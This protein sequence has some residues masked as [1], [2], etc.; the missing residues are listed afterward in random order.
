MTSAINPNVIQDN[1]PVAKSDVRTQLGIARDEISALQAAISANSLTVVTNIAALRLM[2]TTPTAVWVS[3]GSTINDN[4][5]GF[6]VYDASDTTTADNGATVIVDGLGHRWKRTIYKGEYYPEWWGSGVTAVPSAMAAANANGGGIVVLSGNTYTTNKVVFYPKCKLKGQNRAA[7]VLRLANGVNDNLIE[8]LNSPALFGTNTDAGIYDWAIEDVTLD[9][10]MA[11]QSAGSGISIY[12]QRGFMKNVTIKNC[13]EHGMRTEWYSFASTAQP[14]TMEPAFVNIKIETTGQYGWWN[15]GAHDLTAFGVII[16]NASQTTDNTYDGFLNDGAG[17]G[18]FV[19]LHC[20]NDGIVANRHRFAMYSNS[21]G[22]FI[23]SHFE[24]GK[25]GAVALGGTFGRHSFDEACQFYNNRNGGSLMVIDS[26]FN[27]IRGRF[28]QDLTLGW[29][30][31]SAIQLG[32]TAPANVSGNDISIN[33]LNTQTSLIDVTNSDGG[34]SIRIRGFVNTPAANIV[35]AL[36]AN[37]D[38]DVYVVQGAA[39]FL[40]AFN[41]QSTGPAPGLRAEFVAGTGI[42]Q[43]TATQLSNI[44]GIHVCTTATAGVNDAIKMPDAS[45]DGIHYIY[46][47]SGVA[48]KLFPATGD[49]IANQGVNVNLAIPIAKGAI[50]FSDGANHW[51]CVLGA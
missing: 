34:N 6:F 31:V 21:S 7:S 38:F 45:L 10:N 36:H 42:V 33:V 44:Y 14:V 37:D 29:P 8:G 2:T 9:G 25:T 18:R 1:V 39:P 12:G 5:H 32:A 28:F 46:N 35:G 13:K 43:A 51:S 30:N 17:G 11:N 49:E 40:Y 41:H 20:W 47:Y 27:I 22:D 23:G 48:L 50:L 24:G 3:Y 19:H 26:P 4:A 15:K 16:V